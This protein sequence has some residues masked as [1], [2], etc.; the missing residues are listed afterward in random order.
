MKGINSLLMI[1]TLSVF[2]SVMVVGIDRV[3][4]IAGTGHN[5]LNQIIFLSKSA[6]IVGDCNSDPGTIRFWSS[7]DGTLKRVVQLDENQ[8][9]SSIAVSSDENLLAVGTFKVKLRRGPAMGWGTVERSVRCYSIADQRWLWETKVTDTIGDCAGC[10]LET[11]FSPDNER[12][13]TAGGK[14]VTICSVKTGAILQER[15]DPLSRYPLSTYSMKKGKVFSPSGRYLVVWQEKPIPGHEIVGGLFVSKKVTV[16]DIEKDKMV[17]SWKKDKPI[18]SA[19]FSL[20]E[21]RILF[22]S[23]D[24]HVRI[25]NLEEQRV[26]REWMALSRGQNPS[27]TVQITTVPAISSDSKVLATFGDQEV[28]FGVRI[29]DY[30]TGHLAHDFPKTAFMCEFCGDYAM[31]FTKDGRGIA[32]QNWGDLCLYGMQTWEAKWCVPTWPEDDGK[33]GRSKDRPGKQFVIK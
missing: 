15:K 32:F 19:V 8:F 25:W 14:Y 28:R 30:P 23:M 22:T 27:A 20:D 13:F 7:E 11:V 29:W 17:S 9:S 26:E 2:A 10:D 21:R 16:W 1:F 24:G 6:E 31:T 4:S 12:I 3:A 5:R 18:C 33:S